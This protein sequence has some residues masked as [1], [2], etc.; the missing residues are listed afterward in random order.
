MPNLPCGVLMQIAGVLCVGGNI[1]ASMWPFSLLCMTHDY[2]NTPHGDKGDIGM[3]FILWLQYGENLGT[4]GK[5]KLVDYG[6]EFTPEHGSFIYFCSTHV[7]HYTE[8]M[9]GNSKDSVR[10]GVAQVA[11]S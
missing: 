9:D 11:V 7:R 10:F 5:F 2:H 3:S 4:G 6:V 8:A 1:W